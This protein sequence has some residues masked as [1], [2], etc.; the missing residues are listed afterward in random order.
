MLLLCKKGAE[1]DIRKIV[2][3]P[4]EGVNCLERGLA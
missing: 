2:G 4:E 1:L 3:V